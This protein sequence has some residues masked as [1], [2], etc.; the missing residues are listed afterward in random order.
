MISKTT[1]KREKAAQR[2]KSSKP[3]VQAVKPRNAVDEALG[4]SR[5]TLF[6]EMDRAAEETRKKRSAGCAN[7]QCL[8]VQHCTMSFGAEMLCGLE[9]Q[10]YG[11]ACRESLFFRQ[12]INAKG[13]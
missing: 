10:H 6:E 13:M 11:L 12:A 8:A 3:A 1:I 5:L 7:E 2:S 9:C 4:I